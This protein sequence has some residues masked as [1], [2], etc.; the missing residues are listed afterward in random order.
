MLKRELLFF[1]DAT[2]FEEKE[3]KRKL[4]IKILLPSSFAYGI[5]DE[6]R[7]WGAK[8]ARKRR[9][10][11]FFIPV[12]SISRLL[13]PETF[14]IQILASYRVDE[15]RPQNHS[16]PPHE[17]KCSLS[18]ITPS[19]EINAPSQN[20]YEPRYK[21]G[22][23]YFILHSPVHLSRLRFHIDRWESS[24][25]EKSGMLLH[26]RGRISDRRRKVVTG[27]P[28]SLRLHSHH[29]RLSRPES[30]LSISGTEPAYGK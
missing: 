25:A 20:G 7:I 4:K 18:N 30:H 14:F 11:L 5:L 23:I 24:A 28:R 21:S 13:Y 26:V 29:L 10:Q 6:R 1:M 17:Q 8:I 19:V 27:W 15:I 3:T 22:H 9:G 16:P 12:F 2:L